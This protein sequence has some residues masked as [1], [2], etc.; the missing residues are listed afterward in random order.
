MGLESVSEIAKQINPE[1]WDRPTVVGSDNIKTIPRLQYDPDTDSH[2]WLR[3]ITIT[4]GENCIS[5]EDKPP[6]TPYQSEAM[7]RLRG[8]F[9]NKEQSTMAIL[10]EDVDEKI[11]FIAWATNQVYRTKLTFKPTIFVDHKSL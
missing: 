3:A 9:I 10:Y 5:Y 7:L 4:R 2:F 8:V 11:H 6:K 1:L